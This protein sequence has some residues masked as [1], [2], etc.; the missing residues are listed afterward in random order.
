MAKYEGLLALD[1][2]DSSQAFAALAIEIYKSK[3][4]LNPL[5]SCEIL[6]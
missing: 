5:V 6:Y 4:T 2:E 3:N 1:N